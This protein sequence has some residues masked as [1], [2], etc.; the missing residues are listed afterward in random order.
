MFEVAW[1]CLARR[2]PTGRDQPWKVRAVWASA[3]RGGVGRCADTKGRAA[4][5]Y[6]FSPLSEFSV[7]T[8]IFLTAIDRILQEPEKL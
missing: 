7:D 2:A 6:D 5:L 3:V 8:G 1:R 4:K